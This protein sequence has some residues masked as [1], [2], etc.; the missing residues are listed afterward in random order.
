MGAIG[1]CM[2]EIVTPVQNEL[3][4][5]RDE[6]GVRVPADSEEAMWGTDAWLAQRTTGDPDLGDVQS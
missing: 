3:A 5:Q 2:D 6:V 4:Y 1:T